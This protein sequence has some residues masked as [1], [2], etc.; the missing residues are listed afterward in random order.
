MEYGAVHG[1]EN[2]PWYTPSLT[3][4]SDTN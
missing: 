4:D 3:P 1:S 2:E